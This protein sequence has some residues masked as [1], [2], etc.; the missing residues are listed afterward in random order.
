MRTY[1][2]NEFMHRVTKSSPLA[3]DTMRTLVQGV[4]ATNER[5]TLGLAVKQIEDALRPTIEAA[6][7]A[8]SFFSSDAFKA[9]ETVKLGASFKA[10]ENMHRFTAAS[11]WLKISQV[12]ESLRASFRMSET[13]TGAL[14]KETEKLRRL[15]DGVNNSVFSELDKSMRSLRGA[16]EMPELGATMKAFRELSFATSGFQ[17]ATV[18]E[19]VERIRRLTSC[20]DSSVLNKARE[21]LSTMPESSERQELLQDIERMEKPP[22]QLSEERIGSSIA[23]EIAEISSELIQQLAREPEEMRK[24]APRKF[25][26]LV[27]ELLR[28]R[29]C[30]IELTKRTRDGGLDIFV[31]IP[32]PLGKLFGIVECKRHSA[33]NKI[34]VEIVDRFITQVR[35]STKANV[36][37]IA[38]TTSFSRDAVNKVQ[39]MVLQ[40][41]VRFVD[42]ERLKEALSSYGKW[43]QGEGSSLW[44]PAP[45]KAEVRN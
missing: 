17:N 3:S 39:T 29:G 45:T 36:G 16:F 6:R 21:A 24:L 28:D 44:L 18:I 1:D 25:E 14:L 31:L 4:L 20:V 43:H 37:M 9:M 33:R 22:E 34:G 32:S 40:H 10:I 42:F 27:A 30:D 7:T 2:N 26:E 12:S 41:M 19:S 38:A 11:D 13:A 5:T 8:T 35:E 15:V 23:I